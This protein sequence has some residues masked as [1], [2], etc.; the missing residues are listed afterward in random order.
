MSDG[1]TFTPDNRSLASSSDDGSG[2]LW[3]VDDAH[4][5]WR[6]TR[7]GEAWSVTVNPEGDAV[8]SGGGD[9]S[10]RVFRA[11]DGTTRLAFETRRLGVTALAFLPDGTS[12]LSSQASGQLAVWPLPRLGK[13]VPSPAE[14]RETPAAASTPSAACARA[15]ALLDAWTGEADVLAEVSRLAERAAARDD[16]AACAYVQEARVAY[17]RGYELGKAYRPEALDAAEALLDRARTIDASLTAEH[18]ARGWLLRARKD[19]SGARREGLAA[20]TLAPE[21]APAH[22][23]LATEAAEAGELERAEAYAT[24]AL[25][26]RPTR[27]EAASAYQALEEAYARGGDYDAASLAFENESKV[28]P[29]SAWV[30]PNYAS[31]L[32]EIG[33]IAKAVEV[34][35]HA[36][37]FR[38]TPRA[39]AVL[40]RVYVAVGNSWLWDTT[41]GPTELDRAR[42]AFERA[43]EQ[44]PSAAGG[45]YGMA[46]YWR[47]VAVTRRDAEAARKAEG[48]LRLAEA[49]H[50]P[51]A[52]Q[53]LDDERHVSDW[54][55][56]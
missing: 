23:L 5:R 28:L 2:A 49:A 9:G 6:A 3:S 25:A 18:I 26:E 46:A 11:I 50:D 8:A 13:V 36:A 31:F 22:V 52:A 10:I 4:P 20:E 24:Q 47:Y 21:S 19:D 15:S 30:G 29:E 1:V 45:H 48:E 12:L 27:G 17:R 40:A 34:A 7:A 51:L 56:K 55:A 35:K 38:A 54:L 41:L 44:D 16:R 39:H 33:E 14:L 37:D 53:M 32:L 42:K 43:I